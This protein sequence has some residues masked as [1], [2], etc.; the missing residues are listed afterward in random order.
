MENHKRDI[1][2]LRKVFTFCAK[3]FQHKNIAESSGRPKKNTTETNRRIIVLA[4][5]GLLKSS[6]AISTGIHIEIS[7]QQESLVV[8]N[9]PPAFCNSALVDRRFSVLL[10]DYTLVLLLLFLID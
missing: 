7:Q 4:K 10:L 5:N 9:L 3:F 8:K 1:E 6:D 2:E